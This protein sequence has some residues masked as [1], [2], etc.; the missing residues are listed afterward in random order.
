MKEINLF[1]FIG[2][3]PV[4]PKDCRTIGC[5]K[6]AEC[7]PDVD[8]YVCHCPIGTVG[9]G[10]VECRPGMLMITFIITMNQTFEG[11]INDQKMLIPF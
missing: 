10:D 7:V 9:K 1:L 3:A 4:I 8:N 5:G 11:L 2:S 6:G